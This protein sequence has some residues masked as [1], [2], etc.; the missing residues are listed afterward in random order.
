MRGRGSKKPASRTSRDA[1]LSNPNRIRVAAYRDG[2][3]AACPLLFCCCCLLLGSLLLPR[4][5]ESAAG[6]AP[7]AGRGRASRLVQ[8]DSL[9]RIFDR[10]PIMERAGCFEIVLGALDA[11][12]KRMQAGAGIVHI[13][14]GASRGKGRIAFRDAFREIR[15]E[16]LTLIERHGDFALPLTGIAQRALR[17]PLLDLGI[18]QAPVGVI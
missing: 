14:R 10:W 16:C 11:L 9:L 15:D 5:R 13:G 6:S 1:G 17:I 12:L 18:A 4:L 3:T 2:S 8:R 7:I